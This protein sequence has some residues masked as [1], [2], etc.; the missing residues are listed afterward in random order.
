MTLNRLINIT[1]ETMR[2]D[3]IG[4]TR[5]SKWNMETRT[6][7]AI[8][9]VTEHPNLAA[10]RRHLIIQMV[11]NTSQQLHS[12][13]Q[14]NMLVAMIKAV[15]LS[16]PCRMND[17]KQHMVPTRQHI[18]HL[19]CPSSSRILSRMTECLAQCFTALFTY[20][21]NIPMEVRQ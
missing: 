21:L 14:V 8:N 12:V 13:R 9:S 6:D 7:S 4:L 10:P 20:R 2:N 3:C 1:I 16:R 19:V 18:T 11:T 15:T 5:T 17:I